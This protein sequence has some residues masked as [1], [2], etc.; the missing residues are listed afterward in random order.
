MQSAVVTILHFVAADLVYG[1]LKPNVRNNMEQSRELRQLFDACAQ[2]KV[3]VVSSLLDSG[4]DVNATDEDDLTALQL[5]AASG[6]EQVVR[7]L[8]VQGAAVDQ[9]NLAGW[10]PLLHAARNGHTAVAALLVQNH[11]SIDVQTCYGAGIACLAARS[12]NLAMCRLL[13]GA[14]V[15]FAAPSGHV[16]NVGSTLEIAPLVVAAHRGHD[17][18]VKH[19]LSSA[20]VNCPVKPTEVT[21][22]MGAVVGGHVSTAR[23][24]VE[25]GKADVN[26]VDI[27]D[28]SALDYSIALS[29][30]QVKE[31]LQ[32]KTT[33][34]QHPA[35]KQTLPSI[36][37][38]VKQGSVEKVRDILDRDISQRDACVPQDGATPLMFSAML[39]HLPI[40]QLLVEKG[41]N[42][43]AQDVVN[44]WT[45]LMQAIFHGQ[46]EVAVHLMHAGA[47]VTVPAK[48]G[49]NAFDMASIIADVDTELYRLIAAHAVPVVVPQ[50]RGISSQS[51]T[52]ST[53]TVNRKTGVKAWWTR[54]SNRFH[55]LKQ[56]ESISSNRHELSE[57]AD[58]ATLKDTPVM[59]L[60]SDVAVIKSLGSNP[61]TAV[62]GLDT[63]DQLVKNDT[64][65]SFDVSGI[66]TPGSS[67]LKS[68]VPPIFPSPLF[69]N[70]RTSKMPP[71]G[72]RKPLTNQSHSR[73]LS[74][75]RTISS[76]IKPSRNQYSTLNL[77]NRIASP[78]PRVQFAKRP[79]VK[80]PAQVDV[81]PSAS[82]DAATLGGSGS[83]G[84]IA[85]PRT[86]KCVLSSAS[87]STLTAGSDNN[88]DKTS[89]SVELLRSKRKKLHSNIESKPI[90]SKPDQRFHRNMHSFGV[91]DHAATPNL[92][93]VG[94]DS[95]IGTG[96][97][98][99]KVAV[100]RYRD[101]SESDQTDLGGIL[102][103]LSLECYQPVFEEQEV[104]VEAFLTLND[105]DLREL[106]IRSSESRRQILAA[107]S[108][109]NVNKDR[110]RQLHQKVFAQRGI[111]NSKASEA[112]SL[113]DSAID[114]I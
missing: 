22:L 55:N 12:G 31:Y 86:S 65:F 109:L 69:H 96:V 100:D 83:S 10:T 88:A 77:V 30:Q 80:M 40:V 34:C 90:V 53:D 91:T 8:L 17:S 54:I 70:D 43:N 75:T 47:D 62:V 3:D 110:Q 92:S 99:C 98:P 2:G 50:Q 78:P 51:R 101:V 36:I 1:W 76:G 25:R 103:K 58:D 16:G 79:A 72:H 68:T 102:Q 104:D 45:A 106:G 33:R 107:I 105:C 108:E 6:Q 95:G 84:A 94:K 41:C 48:S 57:V 15:S 46:K 89:P 85:L 37:E 112:D 111:S 97:V 4:S 11:A 44:G 60:P 56:T 73:T 38:A 7:L 82:C 35:L 5:A 39:G 18:L 20:D 21:A 14:G 29:K 81:S 26:A 64:R 74:L 9:A 32:T 61:L 24:V 23:L 49:C 63:T 19:L 87:S 27:N 67:A 52:S 42:I 66:M 28:R 71:A 114:R 13:E 93:S 59:T 113:P